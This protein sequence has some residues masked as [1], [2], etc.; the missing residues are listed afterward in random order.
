MIIG[1][2]TGASTKPGADTAG[3]RRRALPRGFVPLALSEYC[4]RFSLAGLKSMLTLVLI[5]HVLSG[6]RDS[7]V[8]AGWIAHALEPLL[9][10]L[11]RIGLASQIYGLTNALLY[12]SIP[13][14]GLLGDRLSGRNGAVYLG[15]LAMFVALILMIGERYFLPALPLFAFGAGTI[16]GNLS[17][18]VGGLFADDTARRRGFAVYL[19]FLNTG[20]ICGPLLCGALGLWGGWHLGLAGAALAIALGLASFHVA[21]ARRPTRSAHARPSTGPAQTAGPAAQVNVA[22]ILATLLA[23]YLCFAAYEQ[24]GNMFLVWARTRVAL[25]LA[26]MALPV[27]WF[28]A[29]DGLFTLG[30]I[31]LSYLGLNLLDRRGLAIGAQA[32]IALGCAACA[33]G[34]LVLLAAE[35]L[36]AGAVPIAVPIAYL[37]LV[38]CAIVL[39]WPAGLSL[40]MEAAPARMAGFWVGLFYLHGFFAHLWVG[41]GGAL[42]ERMAP[43]GFW[44]IHAALA[45]AGALVAGAAGLVRSRGNQGATTTSA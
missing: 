7:F 13:L 41:F 43:T 40:V 9:G 25:D 31:P 10:P 27:A 3:R 24:I 20:V 30:L 18:L 35:A 36:Y 45:A 29:L 26:G 37:L 33:L 1:S 39:I 12:L 32:Q 4:E 21:P 2:D 15:G 14:G 17:V 11:T 28:L 6:E 34:N 8:G 16:K 38:D 5:D 22:L 44:A 42:Y 23:V 19:A